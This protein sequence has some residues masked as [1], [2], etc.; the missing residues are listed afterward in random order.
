MGSGRHCVGF[1]KVLLWVVP[2]AE[3][4]V[5][6][7]VWGS[8][9]RCTGSQWFSVGLMQAVSGLPRSCAGFF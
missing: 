9:M 5:S 7:L 8:H 4:V 1:L 2:G 6:R 3:E